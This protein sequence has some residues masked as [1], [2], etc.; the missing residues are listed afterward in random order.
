L[1]LA[2][3]GPSASSAKAARLALPI[4]RPGVALP[5]YRGDCLELQLRPGAASLARATRR[6]TALAA[7]NDQLATLGVTSIDAVAAA[8]GG[9]TFEP[10]FRGERAPRP[11]ERRTDFTAFYVVTLPA[12]AKL[13]EALDAF[14][15]LA[16][17]ATVAPLAIVPVSAMPND[18]L[19]AQ[20]WWYYE[21]A[22]R[23]DIHAPEAWDITTGDPS[24]LVAIMDT[25][26]LSAHPDLGGTLPSSSGQIFTNEA[27]AHGFDF[28]DD[29]DNGYIDD[30][31]GWDF[32]ALNGPGDATAG[33]D[34][35]NE[36]NDPNDF[37]GHGSAVAGLVA[38]MT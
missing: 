17:V 8:L 21:A 35:Q 7:P 27:E 23:H 11:G 20:S 4:A 26:V 37:A 19:F 29:D 36:D 16:D 28:L 24:V 10:E 2:F 30:V 12:G 18:S 32:V 1:A 6:A 3:V 15:A 22:N 34:W 13:D 38:A 31:H 5:A 25:G 14:G 33:E 9:V